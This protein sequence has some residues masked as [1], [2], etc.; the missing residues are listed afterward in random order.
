MN[1]ELPDLQ[2]N[3]TKHQW[4]FCGLPGQP[5]WAGTRNDQSL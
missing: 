2:D 4:P 3:D 1:C 5:G